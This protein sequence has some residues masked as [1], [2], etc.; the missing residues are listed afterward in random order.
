MK[1]E[2]VIVTS[3]SYQIIRDG[4]VIQEGEIVAKEEQDGASNEHGQG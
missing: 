3:G 4:E 1:V 2:T